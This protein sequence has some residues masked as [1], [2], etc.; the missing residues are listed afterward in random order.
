MR[1]S[2]E[3]DENQTALSAIDD[4]VAGLEAG[5][6]DYMVRPFAFSELHARLKALARRR[7]IAKEDSLL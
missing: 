2:Q 4:R 5:A 6:D 1:R 7:P 3:W